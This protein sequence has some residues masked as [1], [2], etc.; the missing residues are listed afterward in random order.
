MGWLVLLISGGLR[1]RAKG[2][3]C[4]TC[5]R[6]IML[7]ESQWDLAKLKLN[8]TRLGEL[9]QECLYGWSRLDQSVRFLQRNLDKGSNWTPWRDVYRAEYYYALVI[10]WSIILNRSNNSVFLY[11]K[12]YW[13]RQVFDLIRASGIW[14]KPKVLRHQASSSKF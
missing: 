8:V 1:S 12:I 14:R 9:S 6:I 10:S 11:F 5:V 3:L 2:A 7:H 13:N 4:P